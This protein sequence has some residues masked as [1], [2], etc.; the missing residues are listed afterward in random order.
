MPT[1]A[2]DKKVCDKLPVIVKPKSSV[3]KPEVTQ[4]PRNHLEQEQGGNIDKNYCHRG[5]KK[6]VSEWFSE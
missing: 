3:G 6:N 4:R 1:S 5:I 2:V